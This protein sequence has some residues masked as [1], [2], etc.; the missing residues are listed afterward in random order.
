MRTPLQYEKLVPAL[1]K[2]VRHTKPSV[3][4]GNEPELAKILVEQ[5][6]LLQNSSLPGCEPTLTLLGKPVLRA[7]VVAAAIFFTS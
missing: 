6:A 4:S 3:G 2:A 1:D 5:L 7:F